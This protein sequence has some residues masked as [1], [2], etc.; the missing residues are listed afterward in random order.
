[1]KLTRHYGP[2]KPVAA[3]GLAGL[4]LSTACGLII[5][6]GRVIPR[7]LGGTFSWRRGTG[8]RHVLDVSALPEA[9]IVIGPN[10]ELS[11]GPPDRAVLLVRIIRPFWREYAEV[12]IFANDVEINRKKVPRGRHRI[13]IGAASFHFGEYRLTWE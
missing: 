7:R 4:V 12:E 9:A 1:V 13:V 6:R 8:Q 11:V 10:G 3:V 2:A 5:V